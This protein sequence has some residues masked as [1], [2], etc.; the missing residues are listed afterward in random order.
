I[1]APPAASATRLAPCAQTSAQCSFTNRPGQTRRQAMTPE[2]FWIIKIIFGTC[3]G[4]FGLL[5]TFFTFYDTFKDDKHDDTR[6]WF[7][8][9]WEAIKDSRW[10]SLPERAINCVLQSRSLLV[11]CL[12]KLSNDRP[13]KVLLAGVIILC[14][15]G[16]WLALGVY[17][18]DVPIIILFVKKDLIDRLSEMIYN[19]LMA[20]VLGST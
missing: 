19:Y 17:W 7:K 1:I 4:L 14:I 12:E 13:S 8:A 20:T 10:L 2:T 16:A 6:A 15:S 5:A 18:A 3:A 9:K 11:K